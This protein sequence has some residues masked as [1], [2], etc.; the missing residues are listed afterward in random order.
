MSKF[1]SIGMDVV[2]RENL[3]GGKSYNTGFKQNLASVVLS[4]MLKGDQYYQSDADRIRGVFDLVKGANEADLPFIL[5]AMV[6]VRNEGNLR[7]ISHVMANA[8]AENFRGNP[9]IRR[10]LNKTFVRVDDMIEVQALWNSRH[11]GNGKSEMVPNA[12]R[13]AFKDT[14]ETKFDAYQLKKYAN[15]GSAVKLRDIV[16]LAHPK[17]RYELFK[18]VIEGT[19]PAI[20]TMQVKLSSGANAGVAFKELLATK[21]LGYMAAIKNIRNA[22]E[23][24]LDAEGLQLWIDYITNPKAV[25][26]SRMLPFRYLDAWKVMKDLDIDA[27]VKKDI[28]RALEKAFALSAENTGLYNENEKVALILDESGSMSGFPFETGKVLSAATALNMN[29][30]RSV[31]YTF[32][33]GCK[34]QDID[35]IIKSPFD[36]IAKYSPEGGATYFEAPFKKLIKSK[37]FVD[38]II[39]FTDMQLYGAGDFTAYLNQYKLISPNVKVLFWNLQG[40]G[41]GTPPQLKDSVMEVSGYSDALLDVVAKI[42]D[43]PN[44][45]IDTIDAVEL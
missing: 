33:S 7:S 19:L 30:D 17:G 16:Q 39:I 23:N 18:Q 45:L 42:W 35:T 14:L 2:S 36:W 3:A 20:E 37:T 9:L 21:K 5:K 38:K 8:V 28:K 1:N 4:S 34:Q 43:N 10:A 12:I 6:F 11:K 26:N 40:Y 29:A 15:E 22:V 24:G 44:Y 25:K 41:T 27:F 32:D 13:R 31:F